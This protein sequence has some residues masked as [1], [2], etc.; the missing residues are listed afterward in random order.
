M[1]KS[2]MTICVT[3]IMMC[4][5]LYNNKNIFNILD[6]E[7]EAIKNNSETIIPRGL[8][9][10]GSQEMPWYW[11]MRESGFSSDCKGQMIVFQREVLSPSLS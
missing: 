9:N 10:G 2:I 1:L 5:P 4:S 3:L 6:L 11:S 8:S 7:H